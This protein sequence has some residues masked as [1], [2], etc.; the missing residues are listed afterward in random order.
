MNYVFKIGS[1]NLNSS[2]S[3]IN[4]SLLRDFVVNNDVDILF[5]QEVCYANF[6]FILSHSA[7]VNLGENGSGTAILIRN[8]FEFSQPLLDPNGR[9]SSVVVN[10]VNYINIYAFSGS[11]RKKE[12]DNMFV[13]DLSVHFGKGGKKIDV[14]GGDFNCILSNCDSNS[15][16][17]NFSTGLKQLVEMF[18]LKD[19]AMEM[20]KNVFTFI[21]NNSSS[22]LDRFYTVSSFLRNV[23]DFS[24]IP[25]VLFFQTISQF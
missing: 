16:V 10:G 2:T 5:L 3:T 9:I 19:V 1:V 13:N 4:K 12:R 6:S 15:S 24:T 23:N 14:I 18:H 8:S 22:R 17:K 11:N 25:V 7:L 20:K 21:R